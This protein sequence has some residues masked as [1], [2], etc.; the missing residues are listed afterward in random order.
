MFQYAA[1][2]ASALRLNGELVLSLPDDTRTDHAAFGL[3]IFRIKTNTFQGNTGTGKNK[4]GIVQ[5]ALMSKSEK[6]RQ[7]I[8]R[9]T[10]WNGAFYNQSDFFFEPQFT[11]I[12]A[13][14]FIDGYFQSERYFS[15]FITDV[16]KSYDL[17]HIRSDMDP[18]FLTM[19]EA[20]NTVSVHIRRG[21]YAKDP[22][23]LAIHGLMG[24]DYYDRAKNLLEA[25]NPDRHYVIFSDDVDEARAISSDWS[26]VTIVEGNSREVDLYAMSICRDHIIANSSFSWWGAWLDARMD[27]T[28]IAPRKWF[29]RKQLLTTC[30]D[31]LFPEG[32]I[33]L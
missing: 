29:A 4:L 33:L 3:D 11:K 18:E 6:K 17:T 16:R 9:R 27:K 20:M 24:K 21:D 15:D 26:K 12:K 7:K 14:C 5:R 25:V 23:A 30:I 8:Q 13:P 1:G 19:C 32:W 10:G 28:V 31:D 2:L 22:G